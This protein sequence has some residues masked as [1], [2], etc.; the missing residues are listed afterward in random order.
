ERGCAA[1]DRA[2]GQRR[3]DL[4]TDGDPDRVT[5]VVRRSLA[6]APEA[7]SSGAACL[8]LHHED[9]VPLRAVVSPGEA[10]AVTDECLVDEDAVGRIDITQLAVE[11][12]LDA[13]AG[14]ELHLRPRQLA[15]AVGRLAEARLAAL[16]R[17][18]AVE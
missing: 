3:P 13:R 16:R 5:S 11:A 2:V 10:V 4:R 1:R 15:E 18:D 17:V 14:E 12:I 6:A 8:L 9:R 7:P